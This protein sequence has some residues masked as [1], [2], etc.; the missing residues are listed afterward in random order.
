ME[1]C[2]PDITL[3]SVRKTYKPG[4]FKK[5]VQAVNDLSFAIRK[6]EVFGLIGPNGAG[7]STTIRMILGLIRPDSGSIL[8]RDKPLNE[9]SLLP[10]VGYLPENPYLYDH[11]TLLELLNFCGQSSG[12]GP[13]RIK[14]RGQELMLK[15]NLLAAQKRPLR[16]FSKGMLQRAG[17]CFALL[18]DP[19]V[20]ILDEPMSGLDPIGRKMVFDLVM[21]LKDQGKTIFFCSHIL[22][23]VERLCDRIGLMHNGRLIKE[24]AREDFLPNTVNSVFLQTAGMPQTPLEKVQLLGVTVRIEGEGHLLAIPNDKYYSVSRYLEESEVEILGCRSEWMSLED[25]FMQIVKEHRP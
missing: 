4:L 8:F 20:V 17:I 14:T 13:E 7:K 25:L 1:F 23:D 22:N 16:T 5:N 6:G 10:E 9:S 11:L 24:F 3:S 12:L 21:E 2:M 15:L 18:H 19:S